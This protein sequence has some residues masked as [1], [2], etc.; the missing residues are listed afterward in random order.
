[1]DFKTSGDAHFMSHTSRQL[2]SE[3]NENM[4]MSEWVWDEGGLGGS[5]EVADIHKNK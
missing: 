5:D 3:Q 1:M 2:K 4:K